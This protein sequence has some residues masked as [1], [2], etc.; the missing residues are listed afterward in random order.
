MGVENYTRID[1]NTG[2]SCCLVDFQAALDQVVDFALENRIDLVVF[3]GDAYKSRDPSQTHQRA[4]ARRVGRLASRGIAVFLL[5]GNHDLPSAIGRATAIEIFETLAV[6]NVIVAD[7]PGVHTIET[8]GG[9]VQIAALPWLRRGVL[10]TREDAGHLSLDE[11]KLRLEETLSRMVARSARS[12]DPGL[13]SILCAHVSVAN[14]ALSSERGMILGQDPV[15]PLDR[16]ADPAFDYVALGHIHKQQVLSHHPPVVYAGSLQRID[17][18][19][20]DDVK[21]FCVVEID[22]AKRPGERA[23]FTFQASTARRFV[24]IRTTVGADDPD[25]TAT[26]VRDVTRRA[27]DIPGAIVRV[28]ITIPEH[29]DGLISEQEIH[30]VL[31]RAQ[32]VTIAKDVERQRRTRLSGCSAEEMAPVDALKTY[33]ELRNTSAERARTLLEYGESLIKEALS[34]DQEG[35]KAPTKSR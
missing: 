28:H 2:L 23:S 19:D 33:L 9:P 25:P 32:Y 12:V 22:P 8:R 21:G 13:P 20:E 5:V 14:A 16:V 11:L 17:F 29:T 30:S 3:S 6:E 4:F 35:S 10:L 34:Q 24:T 31:S 1:P 7:Q 15:L 26:V 27:E 18:S